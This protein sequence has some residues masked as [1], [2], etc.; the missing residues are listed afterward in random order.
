MT[1]QTHEI[2]IKNGRRTSMAYCPTIPDN[3]PRIVKLDEN[4]LDT[5]RLELSKNL[6]YLPLFSTACWRGYIGTWKITL[7]KLYLVDIIGRYKLASDT[8]LFADWYS[9]VLRVPRGRVL[10]YIHMGFGTVFKKEQHIKIENGVVVKEKTLRNKVN[11]INADE[12]ALKN[13]PGHE[14]AFDGDDEL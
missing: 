10:Q 3:D 13:L 8:P 12:L 14:N 2:L 11:K 6:D 5:L 4:E 7:G 1:A 9:G